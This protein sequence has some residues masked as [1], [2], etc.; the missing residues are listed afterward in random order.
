MELTDDL[1]LMPSWKESEVDEKEK[2][3][4]LKVNSLILANTFSLA[5]L[6]YSKAKNCS[7]LSPSNRMYW[8]F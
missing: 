6:S 1:K 3:R 2:G 7:T 5:T 4:H 8:I